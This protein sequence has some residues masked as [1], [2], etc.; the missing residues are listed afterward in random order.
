MMD[1]TTLF[2]LLSWPDILA[3]GFTLLCWGL[4]GWHVEHPQQSRPSVN[5]LM[6]QYRRAWML[7]NIDR[8]PRV[9][10][11]TLLGSLRDGTAFFASACLIAIGGALALIGNT[12]RLDKV[13]SELMM[14]PTASILWEVKILLPL[15]LITNAFMKFVWSHRV[16]GYCSVMMGAIPN[17]VSDPEARRRALM[18]AELNIEAA[19]S[20]NRGLRSVYFALGALGWLIG[21]VALVLTTAV[22]AGTIWHREFASS[23]RRLL[24]EGKLPEES[25]REIAADKD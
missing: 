22:T 10:D 25:L 8:S 14:G 20:Y 15:L 16:F 24:L 7:N 21:P 2:L 5:R 3:A 17:D 6:R 9:H 19:R 13:A 23:S 12:D 18:A 4:V 11:A 1:I